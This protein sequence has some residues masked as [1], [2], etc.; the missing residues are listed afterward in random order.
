MRFESVT[1]EAYN[2]FYRFR[3]EAAMPHY[4][5]FCHAC[6]KAF[7]KTLTSAEYKE[8]DLVCPYC[9]SEEVEQRVSAFYPISSRESA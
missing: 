5:F 8:G 2:F 3:T 6:K 7:S 9:G 1:A 4:E